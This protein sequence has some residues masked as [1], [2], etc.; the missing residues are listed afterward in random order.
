MKVKYTEEM[1]L[2]IMK[3]EAKSGL[4]TMSYRSMAKKLGG[5]PSSTRP[6]RVLIEKLVA[7]KKIAVIRP[8][9][10][11]S[12]IPAIYQLISSSTN[13]IQKKEVL[14]NEL[15]KLAVNNRVEVVF[16]HMHNIVGCSVGK[17]Y[18]LFSELT[19]ENKI[20]MVRGWKQGNNLPAIF[21]IIESHPV[22]T[23]SVVS[24][25]DIFNDIFNLVGEVLQ[26]VKNKD[27]HISTLGKTILAKNS[28]IG[29]LKETIKALEETIKVLEKTIKALEDKD[30]I[31]K[32]QNL[33]LFN[34]L[35]QLKD[36]LEAAL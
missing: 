8:A 10:K 6:V 21:E 15:K 13:K 27:Q 12:K 29:E 25:T 19:A 24:E 17:L 36:S 16:T 28:E 7:K 35:H 18:C 5:K 3:R 9:V 11:G 1:L 34:K 20:K 33:L 26:I 23:D 22:P 30:R 32:K 14:L 4:V 31:T 2:D